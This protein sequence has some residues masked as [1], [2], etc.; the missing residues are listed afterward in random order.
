MVFLRPGQWC[1]ARH[2]ELVRTILGSCVAVTMFHR[3]SRTGAV[4][5]AVM[6][7]AAGKDGRGRCGFY[8]ACVVHRMLEEMLA[9]GA[10]Q[11]EI[12]TKLFGGAALIARKSSA[13]AVG[14]SNLEQA[15]AMLEELGLSIK[16]CCVG[17]ETGRVLLFDAATGDAFVRRLTGRRYTAGGG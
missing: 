16:T 9:A 8:V 15:R 5:H 13:F 2:G 12:E 14:R 7:A 4:C 10:G 3:V 6:P 17:G 11:G 1:V